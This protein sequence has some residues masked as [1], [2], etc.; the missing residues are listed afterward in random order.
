LVVTNRG[1]ECGDDFRLRAVVDRRKLYR[2]GPAQLLVH[3]W[4]KF[5]QRRPP[6]HGLSGR[7]LKS[8]IVVGTEC[9][10]CEWHIYFGPHYRVHRYISSSKWDKPRARLVSCH[11]ARRSPTKKTSR[12]YRQSC[13]SFQRR[14]LVSLRVPNHLS[15][16]DSPYPIIHRAARRK[17]KLRNNRTWGSHSSLSIP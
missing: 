4:L 1:P 10:D 17:G 5:V 11:L 9:A 14:P 3:G 12:D 8:S 6:A 16:D 2:S 15:P 13:A 7:V